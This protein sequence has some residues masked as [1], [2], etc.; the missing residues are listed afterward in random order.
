MYASVKHAVK[1]KIL[2]KIYGLQKI[3]KRKHYNKF[4]IKR[5]GHQHFT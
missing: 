5:E 1:N 4:Y 2:S 3:N